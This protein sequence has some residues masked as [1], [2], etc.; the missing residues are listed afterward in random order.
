M[1]R[2]CQDYEEDLYFLNIPLEV[3]VSANDLILH[4][5]YTAA[6]AAN[7]FNF[8]QGELDDW[9][10]L[11]GRVAAYSNT[12]NTNGRDRAVGA[13][14]SMLVLYECKDDYPVSGYTT[15]DEVWTNLLTI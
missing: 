12:I 9:N 7:M 13:I 5:K 15:P 14:R 4:G 1:H 8:S 3:F 2:I 6:Q 10:L 11:V